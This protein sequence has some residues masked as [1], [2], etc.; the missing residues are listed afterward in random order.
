MPYNPLMGRRI[1]ET[2]KTYQQLLAGTYK[3][4]GATVR[5]HTK[6]ELKTPPKKGKAPA[7]TKKKKKRSYSSDLGSSDS[8]ASDRPPTVVLT[9]H[10]TE[11]EEPLTPEDFAKIWAKLPPVPKHVPGHDPRKEKLIDDYYGFLDKMHTF[12][13]HLKTS[14]PLQLRA[15]KLKLLL[16]AKQGM[17]RVILACSKLNELGEKFPCAVYYQMLDKVNKVVADKLKRT[18]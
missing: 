8:V 6:K 9:P 5:K 14:T 10:F 16:K 11:E 17:E 4:K 1:S 3:Y 15:L 2:G 13:V 12:L 18:L 7:K